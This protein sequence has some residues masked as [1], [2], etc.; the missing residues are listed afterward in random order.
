[1][2]KYIYLIDAGHG[3]IDLQGNYVTAPNKMYDHGDFKIYEGEFN[4][5]VASKLM[6]LLKGERIKYQQIHDDI[7]D[8]PLR[9]RVERANNTDMLSYG[10]CIYISIHANAGG[11]KN[12]EV[13][14]S[15]RET[16][17]DPIAE[18]WA[19]EC[20]KEFGDGF[21]KDLSD[22]DMD[23]EAKFFVLIKTSCP[24]ILTENFFMDNYV[25]AKKMITEEFQNRVAEVHFR[26]IKRIEK[27]M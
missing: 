17:S 2:S 14:T 12:C 1:M 22:G 25:E 7:D 16:K 11:G 3:G 20:I 19:E 21:R 15:P 9:I 24:A 13:Y 18:I 6:A 10:R 8:T 4:R 23:K 26:A 27:E 5:K